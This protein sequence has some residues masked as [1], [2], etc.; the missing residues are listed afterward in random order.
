LRQDHSEFHGTEGYQI[1]KQLGVGGMGIVYLAEDLRQGI[2]VALKTLK[3]MNPQAL[4][5]FK[6]EFRALADLRHPNLI[7][8]YELIN[9]NGLWFFTMEYLHEAQDFM[10]YVRGHAGHSAVT[11]ADDG[12]T[13]D[14]GCLAQTL[15]EPSSHNAVT[16]AEG[17][18]PGTYNGPPQ[19]R[20]E[21]EPQ[22]KPISTR[23]DEAKVR[24]SFRQLALGIAALHA[25]DKVHRDIKPSNVMVVPGPRPRVVLMDF[26]LVTR[27]GEGNQR[28]TLSNMVGTP[29]YMPPEQASSLEVGPAA[30]WYSF[31]VMLYEVFAGRAPF[32]GTLIEVV[33]A[34]TEEDA[35][36]L[37]I[38]APHAPQDLASLCM[39]LLKR[40][41]GARPTEQEIFARLGMAQED[42]AHLFSSPFVGR[43]N[44]LQRL[45]SA[46][47]ESRTGHAVAIFVQGPS[48]L[49]KSALIKHFLAQLQENHDALIL[50]GRCYEQETVP[51][52]AFDEI[53]DSLSRVLLDMK[54][55]LSSFLPEE[56]VLVGKLFPVLQRIPLLAKASEPRVSSPQELRAQAFVALRE[57]F[58]R[59]GSE[60]PLV[61]FIDDLQWSDLDSVVLLR[62]ILHPYDPASLLLVASVRTSRSNSGIFSVKQSDVSLEHL[63]TALAAINAHKLPLLPL[64]VADA[65]ELARQLAARSGEEVN[66][67]GIIKEAGGHPLFID[68]LLRRKNKGAIK[69]DDALWERVCAH[70]EASRRI[71][72]F[73]AIAGSPLA[74]WVIAE[75]AKMSM[76]EFV[77][78]T[79]DLRRAQIVR[80]LGNLE[81]DSIEPYHDR[82]R[83]SVTAHLTRETLHNHSAQLSQALEASGAA[84][85]SPELLMR[86]L[87]SAGLVA[88]AAALAEKAAQRANAALAFDR[89]AE[90]LRT[91]LRLGQNTTQALHRLNLALAE[92]LANAGRGPEAA[93]AFLEAAKA[94]EPTLQLELKH[95]AAKQ[96]LGSGYVARGLDLLRSVLAE[97]GESMPATPTEA[98]EGFYQ[99]RSLLKARGLGFEARN[100]AQIE[101]RQLILLDV[102]SSI[103]FGLSFVDNIR[104]AYFQTRSLQ[105]ALQVGEPNR[106][107]RSLMIEA[108]YV[109]QEGG[110]HIITARGLYQEACHILEHNQDP[111]MAAFLIFGGAFLEYYE[112]KFRVAAQRF[113]EA[114]DRFKEIAGA[115]W[116]LSTSRIH[117]LRAT[118][119]QGAWEELRPLYNEYIHDAQRRD[120]RFAEQSLRRW[121]NVLWLANDQPEK[122]GEDLDKN[123]WSAPAG[124][125][126]LQHFLEVRARVELAI[127][128]GNAASA[129]W[130]RGALDDA[131][132]SFLF[133]IQIARA[134]SD[135]LRGRLAL[136]QAVA[137]GSPENLIGE[138]EEMSAR[139]FREEANYAS[140]W[141]MLLQAAAFTH[142]KKKQEA[143]YLLHQTIRYASAQDFPLCAAVSRRRQGELLGG[144][145]GARLIKLSE[146]WMHSQEIANPARMSEI[147]APG[148]LFS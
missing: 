55:G 122:A 31:G 52:K 46:F 24:D 117:R 65:Q 130:A 28:G 35:P 86:H 9:E 145:D 1:K 41:P 115:A 97:F 66:I 99:S 12:S 18:L 27:S 74:Q 93:E 91:A 69:L 103:S 20:R 38:F 119:Y 30:D 98:L 63:P 34:K 95:K 116:E 106:L 138:A 120:D 61:L 87:E 114:E 128:R 10:T 71:V 137:L 135:W 127:Y 110:E 14:L 43:K 147:F 72:E 76:P 42:N 100:E 8:L 141:G 112:G 4:Y 3:R 19:E 15:A 48:G 85:H 146:T 60:R 144:D 121:F 126:H 51:Y 83:E 111:Y 89:A 78:R 39:D 118:D 5:H 49:G 6:N 56:A 129:D 94:Q 16:L 75:A 67:E 96:F 62:E 92:A 7:K 37:D 54:K 44:E 47:I 136:C 90:F 70:E 81:S 53:I 131:A 84:E 57:I 73:V 58:R 45:K 2:P 68:E 143:L 88:R 80:T 108:M 140:I 26:G 79:S 125:Y 13:A 21:M 134:I 132:G 133:R 102:F 11:V 109:A 33:L 25:I 101:H 22:T 29:L 105:L 50:S 142:R 40:E 124:G 36:P 23:F 17:S 148:F 139:L 113:H 77:R 59:L 123:P 82:I 32:L 64:P 104:G 107:A